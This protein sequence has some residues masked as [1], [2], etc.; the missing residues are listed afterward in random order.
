MLDVP[1]HHPTHANMFK[2]SEM[3]EQGRYR[4]V[5]QDVHAERESEA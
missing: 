2:H 3:C 4:L 5:T 1:F